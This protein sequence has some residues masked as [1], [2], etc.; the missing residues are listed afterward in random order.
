MNADS[1]LRA[2]VGAVLL[3]AAA[4]AIPAAFLFLVMALPPWE[5]P[6][7]ADKV[8][9][10]SLGSVA[11]LQIGSAGWALSRLGKLRRWSL[12]LIGTCAALL[13]GFAASVSSRLFEN[14]L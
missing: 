5:P 11:M 7:I 6:W 1:V 4:A 14:P 8:L 12:L 9:W 2:V 13:A 3:A 10:L